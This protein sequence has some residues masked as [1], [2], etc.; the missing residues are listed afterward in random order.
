[1]CKIV[2]LVVVLAVV[3][4]LYPPF[5]AAASSDFPI[6]EQ[7]K[8]NVEFWKKV[9][10]WYS[11]NHVI[12]HDVDHLDVVYQVVDL[13]DFY[14][15]ETDLRT[16]WKKVEKIKEEYRDIL[17]KLAGLPVPIDTTSLGE[18]ELRVLHLWQKVDDTDKFKN[19][20][21]RLR[22]QMGQRDK[23]QK[24]LERSGLYLN[25]IQ[26]IF[27]EYGLPQELCYLPHVE[28]SFY[29]KAYSKMGAA[30]LWQFTRSTGRLFMDINYS[31]DERFDPILSTHA[32]AKLLRKNYEELGSW[33]LA[34]TAY[35]HGLAGMKRAK[36]MLNSEDF[37]EIF[38]KYQSRSFGFAS[39]NFYA[40]FIAA[41]EV[42]KN[43]PLYF[44]PIRFEEP[45]EY[46]EFPLPDYIM[47]DDLAK[48][49]NLDRETLAE[50]NPAFRSSLLNSSRRIPKGYKIRLPN[51]DG[52]DPQALYAGIA[53]DK[54][55]DAQIRDQ[56]YQVQRGDN[57]SSIARRYKVP[58]ETLMAL[59]NMPNAHYIREGQLLELPTDRAAQQYAQ[60]QPTSTT[61]D[62]EQKIDFVTEEETTSEI[63][64]AVDTLRK[65]SASQQ[66]DSVKSGDNL[67]EPFVAHAVVPVELDFYGPA[68]P[69][70]ITESE[71]SVADTLTPPDNYFIVQFEQPISDWVIVQPEETL[72][73]YAEWLNTS[74][75]RL[76]DL[77]NIAFGTDIQVGRKF[78]LL[79]TSVSPE[80]FHQKRMEFHK[81]I[82][83]DFF[84]HYLVE[85]SV[86]YTI[87]KGDNVWDLSRKRF[88][89]P[90]WLLVRYNAGRD[91]LR[92]VPG[93]IINVP[94]ITAKK[95]KSYAPQAD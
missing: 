79:F 85:K 62:I 58:L 12:I 88:Q 49:Y 26:E 5:P 25:K 65:E 17:I 21:Q 55:H 89:I 59:N 22:G 68:I 77:N 91:L 87:K 81:G 56:F 8:K 80:L 61:P 69:P 7:I 50:Y 73:H 6:P 30:G 19:A 92:L 18:H 52:L 78:N 20:A 33:P 9:Y 2:V 23:F 84:A 86:P 10:A 28:S 70:M 67:V 40:E 36:S 31:I 32:A 35:N 11:S 42:A 82:Q 63:F 47:L 34:I 75:Q 57:L 90:Y 38:E 72:G 60:V 48:T 14:P 53:D 13:N 94:V 45:V 76:R 54:R 41:A 93:E 71:S 95:E 51:V 3:V 16:K 27:G 66:G 29:Y 64:V 37:G 83:E 74:A 44:G 39:K 43:Y 4:S 1:M 15:E 46:K 24:G